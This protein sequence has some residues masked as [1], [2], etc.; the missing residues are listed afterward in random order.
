MISGGVKRHLICPRQRLTVKWVFYAPTP[1]DSVDAFCF[2][3]QRRTSDEGM[4]SA[5]R[6]DDDGGA[7]DGS[8][9]SGR[10]GCGRTSSVPLSAVL[11]NRGRK[12]IEWAC[13]R[14]EWR[15]K[16]SAPG[17]RMAA[18]DPVRAWYPRR[19][20][21][22]DGNDGFPASCKGL[23][24]RWW[25]PPAVCTLLPE[26]KWWRR[27]ACRWLWRVRQRRK[28]LRLPSPQRQSAVLS[29]AVE[30][31]SPAAPFCIWLWPLSREIPRAVVFGCGER[32]RLSDTPRV[33]A[34][35]WC[36]RWIFFGLGRLSSVISASGVKASPQGDDRLPL[37]GRFRVSE[38]V[39][40]Q[41][42][43]S[44][45]WR[46]SSRPFVAL[47]RDTLP[48]CR[49]WYTSRDSSSGRRWSCDVAGSDSVA[50]HWWSLYTR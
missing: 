17:R 41:L 47:S 15:P 19:R 29:V 20:V 28:L 3:D 50:T 21:F 23:S 30:Y 5:D 34:C 38:A 40:D 35:P 11:H 46:L 22:D 18:S 13:I 9:F 4:R 7:S 39:V 16:D 37:F 33:R 10:R 48:G 42:C 14:W 27:R 31:R 32:G 8:A 45:H 6:S 24:R 26:M 43:D 36:W 44:F 49:P 1:H 2:S 12:Y 25:L